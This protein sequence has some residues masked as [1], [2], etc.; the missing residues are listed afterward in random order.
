MDACFEFTV[1]NFNFKNAQGI[2]NFMFFRYA[3]HSEGVLYF[4]VSW[5]Y[6]IDFLFSLDI[7]LLPWNLYGDLFRVI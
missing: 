6:F 5:P 4:I 7:L 2:G 3:C 1:S